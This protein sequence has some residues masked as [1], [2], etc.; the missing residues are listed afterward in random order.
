[1]ATGQKLGGKLRDKIEEEASREAVNFYRAW[2]QKTKNGILPIG[3]ANVGKTTFLQRF[4]IAEPSLFLDFNRTLGTSVDKVRLRED[5][6]REAK[7]IEY[8]RKIDVPGDLP[9]QWARAYFDHGPRVLVVLVD[10]RDPTEHIER[11]RKF[12]GLIA[13]GPTFWQRTKEVLSFRWSNLS[14]VLFVA[15]KAD[16]FSNER[17]LAIA[18]SYRGVLADL[19]S[20]LEVPIQV[21]RVSLASDSEGCAALFKAVLDGLSRK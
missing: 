11:L 1:M 21:Y 16:R 12:L 8:Y 15:N 4:E 2:C 17:L 13:E 3:I 6:L 19:Q 7:G 18:D 5:F 10:E 14:R 20:T 9:D